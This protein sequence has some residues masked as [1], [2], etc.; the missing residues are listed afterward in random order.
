[1]IIRMR[2]IVTWVLSALLAVAF[3]FTGVLMLLR[4]PMQ[5]HG[6]ESFGYPLWF[7]DVTGLLELAG[8]TLVLVPRVAFFGAAL[9]TCVM[10]G[11]VFSHLA[12]GQGEE[13]APAAVL[14]VIALV[15]G[16]L[17]GWGRVGPQRRVAAYFRSR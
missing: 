14:L 13:A 16:T 1:M 6:F 8:A 12:H 11:A 7:M 4:S 10:V 15:V 2:T 17:R 9:L 5:V 3:V